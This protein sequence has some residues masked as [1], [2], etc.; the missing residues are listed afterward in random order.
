M[1]VHASAA[2]AVGT[3]RERCVLARGTRVAYVEAMNL[4][5]A[6][7][8]RRA[9]RAYTPRRVEE[10]VL[11]ELLSAAVCAPSAMNAQPWLFAVVQDVRQLKRYSDQAKAMVIARTSS[12]PKSQLYAARMR[13]EQFNVFY[14]ASTLVAIGTA[15]RATYSEADCW[16]AAATLMLAACNVGIGTCPIGFAVPVLNTPEAKAELGF[17]P[18]AAVVAPIV[19]GYPSAEPEPVPRAQPRIV[20]WSRP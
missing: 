16:L 17:P 7:H 19:L 9:V 5:E 8:T 10:S 15:D 14:N 4:H 1:H 12:D 6:I 3:R 13:D 18:G 20:S 2:A 11:R